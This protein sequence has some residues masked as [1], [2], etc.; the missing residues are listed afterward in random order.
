MNRVI[1]RLPLAGV[2][3]LESHPA[4]SLCFLICGM[5][6]PGSGRELGEMMHGQP[7]QYFPFLCVC[8]GGWGETR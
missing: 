7:T 4:R 2:P 3:L 6:L 5:G 1:G 8:W